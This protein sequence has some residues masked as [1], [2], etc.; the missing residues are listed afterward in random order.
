MRGADHGR[1]AGLRAVRAGPGDDG[2]R[3]LC[4]PEGRPPVRPGTAGGGPDDPGH[5]GK[6]RRRPGHQGPA[7]GGL[8][9][10]ALSGGQP[11]SDPQRPHRQ[12]RHGYSRPGGADVHESGAD[13]GCTGGRPAGGQRRG[14]ARG[15]PGLSHLF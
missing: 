14:G 12:H 3:D 8:G 11:P 9:G 5:A 15:H 13:P 2:Y 1:G 10:A 4:L 7:Q 6:R